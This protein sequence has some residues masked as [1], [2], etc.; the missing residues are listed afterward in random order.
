MKDTFIDF[1]LRLSW[2]KYRH[3]TC[4]YLHCEAVHREDTCHIFGICDKVHGCCLVHDSYAKARRVLR[5]DATEN[6]TF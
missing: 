2:Q 1:F 3:V 6:L 5:A 4:A